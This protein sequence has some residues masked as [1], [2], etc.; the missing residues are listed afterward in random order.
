MCLK[1]AWWHGGQRGEDQHGNWRGECF[2]CVCVCGCCFDQCLGL[3]VVWFLG[4]MVAWWLVS[5]GCCGGFLVVFA[6]AVVFGECLVHL[7]MGWWV[8]I[9]V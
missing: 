6:V 9:W 2:L 5:C 7:D 3:V 8:L 4:L 1:S